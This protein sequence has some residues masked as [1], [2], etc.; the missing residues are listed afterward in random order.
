MLVPG[1]LGCS[2]GNFHYRVGTIYLSLCSSRTA[3]YW[4]GQSIRSHAN[5]ALRKSYQ[6]H[7]VFA[8]DM[9][10]V[11]RHNEINFAQL[12]ICQT[13]AFDHIISHA[14]FSST[15]NIRVTKRV[16]T[17]KEV[18][19]FIIFISNRQDTKK[20]IVLQRDKLQETIRFHRTRRTRPARWLYK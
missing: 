10:P 13:I 19:I 3:A 4:Q 12:L 15:L 20:P 6:S 18:A 7:L 17:V 2:Q 14:C 5:Y 11:T 9:H 8:E 16:L 1:R